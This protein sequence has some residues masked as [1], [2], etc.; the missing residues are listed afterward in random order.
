M[1]IPRRVVAAIALLALTVPALATSIATQPILI[2][3][4]TPGGAL[5][6]NARLYVPAPGLV[7]NPLV[8]RIP[9]EPFLELTNGDET[10]RADAVRVK[11]YATPGGRLEMLEAEFGDNLV[12]WETTNAAG[13]RFGTGEYIVQR[14]GDSR[15]VPLTVRTLNEDR[16]FE[17]MP[18]TSAEADRAEWFDGRWAVQ[19]SDSDTP[20]VGIFEIDDATG[21]ATGTFLNATGDFRFL[22]G[23]AQGRL[24][25][26]SAF[27]GQH[28]FL[29]TAIA[30]G[31]NRIEGRFWSG[32]WWHETWVGERDNA[33][34]APDGFAQ[35]TA[36]VDRLTPTMLRD[37][38]FDVASSGDAGASS[39][40]EALP[41]GEPRLLYIFG[42]WC[43]NCRDATEAVRKIAERHRGLRVAALAFENDP[44]RGISLAQNYAEK[45]ALDFPV[46]VGG[47]SDKAE[48]S[49]KV[50]F[51]DKVRSYP[52]LVFI[53]R[54]GTIEAVHSGW[55]GPA[56]GEAYRQQNI[57]IETAVRAIAR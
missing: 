22:E 10:V 52:T 4:V 21:K 29:F 27:D 53:A 38:T 49:K 56:T 17:N 20:S 34:A 57:A 28:A 2:E 41:A 18:T 50:P 24:L 1:H 30:N 23:R 25:R 9:T 14:R 5:P 6:V 33:A 47:F 32:N 26:L 42:T 11:S 7:Q 3:L 36:T 55:S 12:R 19:F 51:L 16:R 37:L 15:R 46:L 39:M 54:D 43:P 44:R 13:Y 31:P 8:G 40:I 45:Y 35:T 48:S